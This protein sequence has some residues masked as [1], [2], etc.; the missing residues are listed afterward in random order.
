MAMSV[1]S[2]KRLQLPASSTQELKVYL[3]NGRAALRKQAESMAPTRGV[4][5]VLSATDLV[6]EIV[7]KL[8]QLALL[9]LDDEVGPQ[10]RSQAES[11]AVVAVGG[12]GRRE[13]CPRSD[14]D[15]LFLLARSKAS[16]H[17]AQYVNAILYGLWD[18]GFEV[19]HAV[20]TVEECLAMAQQDQA[21][22]TGLLDARLLPGPDGQAQAVRE[23]SFRNLLH[24][25]DRELLS[26][27]G[28]QLLIEQKL[29]EANKRREKFGNSIYL[30]EPN[31]K[32]SEGGL[33]ELHTAL[34]VARARWRAVGIRDLL[35]F[36]VLS[37]REGRA[38]ERAY[39][40]L[41]R[42]RTEIHLASGRRQDILSFEH[43]E[44][45]AQTLGYVRGQDRGARAGEAVRPVDPSPSGPD[46]DKKRHGVERFMR[47]YYY[48]AR[49]IRVLARLIIERA[50]SH[51]QSHPSS[52]IRAP[53]GFKIWGGTLTV[54]ERDQFQHDPAALVRIFRVAQEEALE[55]Y[56]YTKD[57]IS[58]SLRNID[59]QVRRRREVVAD[60]LALLEDPKTDGS[61]LDVMHDLGVLRRLIPEVA[62]MTAKWQHSLYHV[63]TVDI[64]SLF[65]VR[66]LKLLRNGGYSR[67]QPE[68]TRLIGELPRPSVLYMAGFLHDIGKGWNKGDHSSRG[69]QI[70]RV[71][72]KRFEEATIAN[73]TEED[74][75]DLVWLVQEHLTMS[76]ISQRRDV[77]DQD[78]IE[79]FAANCASLE[80]LTMLY[81]LTYADMKGTS[82]KVW[83]DW[84]GTLL[85]EVFEITK[86]VLSSAERAEVGANGAAHVEARRKRLM[87]EVLQEVDSRELE[88]PTLPVVRAFSDAMSVRYMLSIP[89]RRMLRHVEMWR[90]VSQRGGF[91][92]HIRQLRREGTTKLTIVCP[93]RP[94]LLALLAGTMT[95]NRLQILSAQIFSM[96]PMAPAIEASGPAKPAQAQPTHTEDDGLTYDL[97]VARRASSA[98]AHPNA[99]DNVAVDVLYL[100]DENGGICEDPERWTR[101]R[102]DLLRVVLGEGDVR[103]L[104]DQRVRGSTL[105]EKTKPAVK[106]E[107]VIANDVSKTET[108]IDVFCQDRLGAL[109]TI[110]RALADAGLTISVAKIST[111]GDRVADGFYVTDARSGL[112]IEDRERLE[113]I[114]SGVRAAIE[115][116]STAR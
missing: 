98:H 64:H 91:A 77:S 15:L 44:L 12:Y 23:A 38:L 11:V 83:S 6:D 40:F 105:K 107:I 51:P 63:Y 37:P 110:S 89:A 39:G 17:V 16:E 93:D 31:V 69:A 55:I 71:V 116:A 61:I 13:L 29:D 45:I 104:L 28:A 108:V 73:W 103:A 90:E 59:H 53:G 115:E 25:I 19:G 111:Q 101:V 100:K 32:A 26:G 42:V 114:R 82:P 7:G 75:T 21:V 66:N 92:L 54:A 68:L 18:L 9:S 3:E 80:R 34:W 47:K 74:T 88:S 48:H 113:A 65:V 109:Y 87:Q 50:T 27:K 70:A 78:L 102:E 46:Q 99:S 10:G 57:L 30:L 62:R 49:Q 94:G 79:S 43:Q 84:K 33:R 4:E 1:G 58:G 36:G 67:E 60:F 112:K 20:R 8:S 22:K 72:G 5:L 41:L 35:R 96:P 56:S 14:V 85:K 24:E 81:L 76:D 97:V 86:M 52:S 106:T 2:E 95:A